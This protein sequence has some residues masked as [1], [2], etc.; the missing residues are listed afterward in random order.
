M[1]IIIKLNNHKNSYLI[2]NN[3]FKSCKNTVKE[4]CNRKDAP[5]LIKFRKFL[6]AEENTNSLVNEQ[7]DNINIQ[8]RIKFL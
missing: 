8:I 7:K 3:Y 4:L 5:T 2:E 1:K 6:Y